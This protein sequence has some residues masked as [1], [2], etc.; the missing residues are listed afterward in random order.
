MIIVLG[1]AA[2]FV[3]AVLAILVEPDKGD[4]K[5]HDPRNNLPI[6]ALIGRR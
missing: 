6:W 2:I 4:R 1:L 3:F 5:A